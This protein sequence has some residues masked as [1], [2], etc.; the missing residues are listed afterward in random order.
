MLKNLSAC[1][2]DRTKRPV[3]TVYC[4]YAVDTRV[5]GWKNIFLASRIDRTGASHRSCANF[6]GHCFARCISF[7]RSI[8]SDIDYGGY[9]RKFTTN[10][11]L[12]AELTCLQ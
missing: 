2:L 10:Q 8:F 12:L 3:F 11:A 1:A 6:S 7:C 9:L 4:H 5:Y